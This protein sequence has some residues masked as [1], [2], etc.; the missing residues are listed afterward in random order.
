M[1]N[2]YKNAW[3]C[4]FISI[5]IIIILAI[6][7]FNNNIYVCTDINRN[8]YYVQQIITREGGDYIRL[9]DN[10]MLKINSYKRIKKEVN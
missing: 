2:F 3:I 7:D 6:I 4:I 8:I 1:N 10:T 5:I 9:K